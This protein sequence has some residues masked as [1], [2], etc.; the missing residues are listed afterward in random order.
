MNRYDNYLSSISFGL[1]QSLDK[2]EV[3]PDQRIG[4]IPNEKKTNSD[5]TNISK[6][7]ES[8]LSWDKMSHEERNSYLY[9]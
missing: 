7:Y 3:Y 1:N 8:S 2:L 5:E 6:E 4:Y 9:G